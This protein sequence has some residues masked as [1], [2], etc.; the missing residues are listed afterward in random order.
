MK[1]RHKAKRLG[2]T[3]RAES[4]KNLYR[5]AS[6]YDYALDEVYGEAL[7]SN[8]M[9]ESIVNVPNEAAI[10]LKLGFKMFRYDRHNRVVPQLKIVAK[11][12][13]IVNGQYR[14]RANEIQLERWGR[15]P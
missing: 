12:R 10:L 11:V 6:S 7:R 5:I 1:L 9:D 2:K 14:E 4:I 3:M 15:K 8:K 13:K